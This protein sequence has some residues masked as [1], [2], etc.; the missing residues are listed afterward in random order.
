MSFLKKLFG[1]TEGGAPAKPVLETDHNG[2][3]IQATPIKEDGQFRVC[4]MISKEVDGESRQHKLVRA[5][6]CTSSNEAAEI[7]VRKSKQMI[8]EQGDRIFG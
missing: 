6:V 3:N 1:G 8:D 5:D 7:A 4:A 2:Y